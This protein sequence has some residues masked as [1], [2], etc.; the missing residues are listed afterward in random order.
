MK[1]TYGEVG[2][3]SYNV[4]KHWH[5]H[6]KCG[7]TPVETASIPG[8]PQ[9]AIDDDSIRHTEAAILVDRLCQLV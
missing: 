8:R 4:D 9:S 5:R 6:Y 2:A 7:R 1:E 3:P